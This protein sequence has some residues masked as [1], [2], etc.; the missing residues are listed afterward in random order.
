MQ[1]KL[2]Y[3][4]G[5]TTCHG[6]IAYDKE[7]EQERPGI[8]VAPA[9]RGLDAFA[10]KKA[11]ELAQQGYVALAADI[12]GEGRE[13]TND[14]EAGNLMLPLFLDRLL[15]QERVKGAFDAIQKIP[16]CDK[17]RIG[18]IGFC[19]GGLTVIEL[20]RSGASI[21]G[22]VSF[23]G[24]LGQQIGGKQ[25]NAVPIAK[26]IHASLLLLH[27]HEDPLVSNED[28]FRMQNEMTQA[29]VDWQMHIYGH[30]SH[31]FTN[32]NAHDA[33]RGMLYN[34]LSAKRSWQQMQI[35]FAEIFKQD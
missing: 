31:A 14:E 2:E 27:G 15:L 10:L 1:E 16:L 13:A 23:H 7:S 28:I 6:V 30:T 17:K 11:E 21:R 25:A 5:A 20:L 29:G 35:F 18:A 19:F 33:A 32:P 22:A 34:E 26:D 24:V 4:A 8:I 9:W 3:K 12:Y